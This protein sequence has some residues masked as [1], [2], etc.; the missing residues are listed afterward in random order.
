MV[1]KQKPTLEKEEVEVPQNVNP[2]E[3]SR[4]KTSMVNN[5]RF[6]HAQ[7]LRHPIK[8]SKVSVA[9]EINEFAHEIPS[10][11]GTISGPNNVPFGEINPVIN[12]LDSE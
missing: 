6:L 3:S 2:Q 5:L 10:V 12:G 11:S 8:E 9:V 1:N 7:S 4:I